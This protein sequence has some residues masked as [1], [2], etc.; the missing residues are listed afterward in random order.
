M[1]LFILQALKHHTSKLEDFN[2]LVDVET[3]GFRGEAL[4]SLCAVGE[5][6][7]IT[8][9]ETESCGSKLTF[10]YMGILHETQPSARQVFRI[11]FIFFSFITLNN[12]N[13]FIFF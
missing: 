4:S 9:H 12:F 2:D 7:V 10:N 13:Y 6:T 1:F 5:L 3:F 8:R 11:L